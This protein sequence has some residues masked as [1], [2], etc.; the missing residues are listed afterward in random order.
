MT[1]DLVKDLVSEEVADLKEI[2]NRKLNL[3]C[4]NLPESDKTDIHDRHQEDVDFLNNVLENKMNLDIDTISVNKLVR[5]GRREKT[6]DGTLKCRPLRF[7]VDLF[8][9]KRQI[10]KANSLL[11]NC[12]DD[13]YSNIY[14]TRDLTK[15]QRKRAF[16]LRSERHSREDKGEKNLKISRGKIVVVKENAGG[17]STASGSSPS[18]F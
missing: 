1:P 8:D 10:L 17:G 7:S 15:N 5:L 6:Q 4:L 16:D 13:I 11:R 9:H 12:V 14:F 18:A 2:E 3:I